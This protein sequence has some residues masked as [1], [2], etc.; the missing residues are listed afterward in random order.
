MFQVMKNWRLDL[1]YSDAYI[2]H[3]FGGWYALKFFEENYSTCR[4]FPLDLFG[5][6][7]SR[8]VH[9][10]GPHPPRP[11]SCRIVYD[12]YVNSSGHYYEYIGSRTEQLH[13]SNICTGRGG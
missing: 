6:S 13:T 1:L 5:H 7:R 2:V 4:V 12:M 3:F 11:C 9:C 8:I 10:A